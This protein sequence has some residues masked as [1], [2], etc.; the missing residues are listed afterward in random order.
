[1]MTAYA[2][3]LKFSVISQPVKIK[4]NQ[5]TGHVTAPMLVI[6]ELVWQ[7]WRQLQKAK[8]FPHKFPDSGLDREGLARVGHN[9]WLPTF[10]THAPAPCLR[11]ESSSIFLGGCKSLPVLLQPIRSALHLL[12]WR[13]VCWLPRS[14]C[15]QVTACAEKGF[16][17]A[18][19]CWQQRQGLEM[20]LWLETC[21]ARLGN[22]YSHWPDDLHKHLQSPILSANEWH[23]SY[24]NNTNFDSEW[25]IY[26]SL[27][28][29][30]RQQFHNY[31]S[32]LI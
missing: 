6:N 26:S 11:G 8:A 32:S 15:H 21:A 4:R 23:I 27:I 18:I 5:K 13:R 12:T 10:Q 25:A 17:L 3:L 1:M 31:I 22:I 29:P 14:T 28:L 19:S 2:K 9:R 7:T 20:A 16:L 24:Q 30:K